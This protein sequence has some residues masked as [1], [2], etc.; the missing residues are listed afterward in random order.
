MRIGARAAAAAIV[1]GLL[2]G[3][4]A[5]AAPFRVRLE[6]PR[7]DDHGPGAYAYPS[8]DAYPR[9][10]FD[11]LS[12]EAWREGDELVLE[13][14]FAA[15]IRAPRHERRTHAQEIRFENE[16]Y[17]QN[18]DIYVDSDPAGGSVDGV[19]GRNVRI[20]AE[21]A[22][23]TVIVLTPMPF[24]V[25]GILDGWS[26]G[27][28]VLVPPDLRAKGRSVRARIPVAAL[29]AEPEA[30]WGWTV[31]ISGAMWAD[32]FDAV[33]RLS[34]DHVRN[35]MTMPVFAVEETAAFGGGELGRHHPWVIDVLV[36]PGSSQA[37]VL[38]AY[39]PDTDRIAA[40]PLVYPDPAARSRAR[41]RA[42]GRPR[43]DP[44]APLPGVAA[45]PGVR[46][47][48]KTLDRDPV[49]RVKD[50]RGEMVV[51]DGV[52]TAVKPYQLGAVL[53][54]DDEVVG[55]IVVDKVYPRYVV[56]TAVEGAERL[57]VGTRVRF[58]ERTERKE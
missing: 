5:D 3:S 2:G 44:S 39:D 43:L 17:V 48:T 4:T 8:G 13:V 10:S 49:L 16:L 26:K 20:D 18:V 55:W 42:E 19:P 22:W 46:S 41:T 23:E 7:G 35:A 14:G 30:S 38:S 53:G 24:E 32:N 56:G 50:F 34:G 25:R 11:L 36:P 6:D 58:P 33:R 45:L 51:L 31:A 9:G 12:F 57:R 28:R 1:A 27:R 54:D 21:S 40:L 29:G 37:R 15:V 52:T 47:S